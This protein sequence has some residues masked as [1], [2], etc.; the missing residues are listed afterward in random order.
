MSM[1]SLVNSASELIV[2][3]GKGT[4][5]T[6]RVLPGSLSNSIRYLSTRVLLINPYVS[7]Q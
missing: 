1:P 6:A 5:L 2:C 4:C 7:Y 3:A